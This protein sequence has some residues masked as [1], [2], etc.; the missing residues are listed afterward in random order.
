MGNVEASLDKKGV[1]LRAT[2]RR[3]PGSPVKGTFFVSFAKPVSPD[4]V[5]A[6]NKSFG[7]HAAVPMH[8]FVA[9]EE[10]V[11]FTCTEDLIPHY[12][13]ALDEYLDRMNAEVREAAAE[14]GDNA[15]RL[16]ETLKQNL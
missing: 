2:A 6:F 3:F 13:A 14:G 16:I 10:G 9:S 8:E 11:E 4:W 15:E 7:P 12:V 5:T 1:E